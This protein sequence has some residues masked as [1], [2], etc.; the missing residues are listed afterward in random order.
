MINDDVPDAI[1]DL[2]DYNGRIIPTLIKQTVL[3]EQTGYEFTLDFL[4]DRSLNQQVLVD[5]QGKIF[6]S[7]LPNRE[8]VIQRAT[9][10]EMM[11]LF[12]ERAGYI[13]QKNKLFDSEDANKGI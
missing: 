1:I 4:T 7:F 8:L 13:L 10:Q 5:S 2:I 9:M 6:K 11:Y 3:R 12:P